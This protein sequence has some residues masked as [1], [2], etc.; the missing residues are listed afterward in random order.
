M[1]LDKIFNISIVQVFVIKDHDDGFIGEGYN[2]G[3]VYSSG[4]ASPLFVFFD[5]FLGI[6]HLRVVNPRIV[7]MSPSLPFDEV[8]N[9]FIGL[10]ASSSTDCAGS[11]VQDFFNFI[12]LFI[13]D[14]VG[15]RWQWDFL[16]R[17]CWQDVRGQQFLVEA[18]MNLPVRQKL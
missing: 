9:D 1:S 11:R 8:V 13:I 5:S 4:V 17:E 3:H 15:R 2:F 6:A 12:V 18:W 14:Q 10:L 7:L 16:I